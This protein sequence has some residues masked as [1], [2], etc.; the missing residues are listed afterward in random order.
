[1][2]TGDSSALLSSSSDE[3]DTLVTDKSL[4]LLRPVVADSAADEAKLIF[5]S[6]RPFDIALRSVRS[7][8]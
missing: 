7:V 5:S 8:W 4:N 2:L 1:M 3:F 6:L